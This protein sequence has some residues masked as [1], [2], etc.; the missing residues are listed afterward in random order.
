[1]SQSRSAA[2]EIPISASSV[3]MHTKPVL[4]PSGSTSEFLLDKSKSEASKQENRAQQIEEY[5]KFT[6]D[7][8]FID[9]KSAGLIFFELRDIYGPGSPN[10]RTINRWISKFNQEQQNKKQQATSSVVVA[11]SDSTPSEKTK[12]TKARSHSRGKK[13]I[14]TEFQDLIRKR[15]YEG[16]SSDEIIAELKTT[17]NPNR[18]NSMVHKLTRHI[19]AVKGAKTRTEN[20]SKLV[21]ENSSVIIN[22]LKSIRMNLIT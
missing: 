9:G 2:N 17:T 6:Y 19:R 5:R 1:M 10:K 20:S 8:F 7:G 11:E 12:S 22:Q 13:K 3:E 16:K 4:K 14:E 18:I 21:L 15:V